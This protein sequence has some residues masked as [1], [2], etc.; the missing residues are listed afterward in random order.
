MRNERRLRPTERARLDHVTAWIDAW[1]APRG[2]ESVALGEAAGRVLAGS[3]EA[4]LDLPPF[5]RAAADGCA[6]RADET[7]GASA[8]NPLPFRLLPSSVAIGTGCAVEVQS[9]DPLPAGADA[10]VR[11]DHIVPDAA[12]TIAIIG[13]VVAGNEVEGK[14]SHAA[15]GSVL[16][17]ASRRLG[18]GE[19]GLLASAGL[20]RISVIGRPRVRCLSSTDCVVA[21]G[22]PLAARETYDANGALLSVLVERD[23]GVIVDQRGVGRDRAALRA[24]L[25]MP[26]ADLILVAGGTGPG[27]GD[28]AAEALA[29][30]GEMCFHG[31]ALRP[32]ETAGAGRAAGTPVILLPGPPAPCLWAYEFLAGRAIRRLA[33]RDPVL[34]FATERLR[35][36]RK[37]V[38]E[39]GIL[40]V[41]PVRRAGG[42]AME[43][44]AAFAEMGLAAVAQADGF[45]LVPE[46]SE[47][48][49]AGSPVTVYLYR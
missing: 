27:A 33:G 5:D 44:V 20:E 14:G 49:P 35:T 42:G 11:L 47:G 13:P 46:T 30:A 8:Y 40:E 9:G 3:V 29:E 17:S 37:I 7:V 16:A 19:I 41:C 6:L 26:G 48:Y 10:V 18:A 22:R 12:G 39:I 32:G 25:Q 21:A 43:P 38:S 15:R 24:A 36:V 2:A 23:G 34:P 31:I 4:V 28:H 45:V 1:A